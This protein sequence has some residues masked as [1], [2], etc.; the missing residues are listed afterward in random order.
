MAQ[1]REAVTFDAFLTNAASWEAPGRCKTARAYRKSLCCPCFA[2]QSTGSTTTFE[3]QEV[4]RQL[5]EVLYH[6]CLID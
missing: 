6:A 5:N 1:R 4:R 3:L 2:A